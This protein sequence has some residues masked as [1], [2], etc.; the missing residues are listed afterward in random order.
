[1]EEAS[2]EDS[3]V[4]YVGLHGRLEYG[5]LLYSACYCSFCR[6]WEGPREMIGPRGGGWPA[7]LER[8]LARACGLPEIWRVW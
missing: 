4:H 3:G 8:I 7:R 5:E 2:L 1:M 6:R